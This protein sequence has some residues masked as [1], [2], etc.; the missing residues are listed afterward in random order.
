MALAVVLNLLAALPARAADCAGNLLVSCEPAFTGVC[1]SDCE[2]SP[3]ADEDIVYVNPFYGCTWMPVPSVSWIHLSTIDTSSSPQSFTC[4]I[5]AN[6]GA[7]PRTGYIAVSGASF[8]VR[9][10]GTSELASGRVTTSAGV[11]L[12]GVLIDFSGGPPDVSTDSNGFWQQTGFV[13]CNFTRA[14]P[15]KTGYTFSPNYRSVSAGQ[16]DRDFTAIPQ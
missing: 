5:D 12:G 8:K 6:T 3:D 1:T 4:T 7:L 13:T 16:F 14:F 11:G 15:I 2:N 9:Q 10:G